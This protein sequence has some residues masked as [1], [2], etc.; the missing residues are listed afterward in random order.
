MT[1]PSAGMVVP[2]MKKPGFAASE[3]APLA[4]PSSVPPC[5][6]PTPAAVGLIAKAVAS[7]VPRVSIDSPRFGWLPL[8]KS[9]SWPNSAPFQLLLTEPMMLKPCSSSLPKPTVPESR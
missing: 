1:P 4:P 8:T 2:G 6:M 5:V 3:V 7:G 9:R